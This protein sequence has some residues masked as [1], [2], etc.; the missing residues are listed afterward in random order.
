MH[1][2]V[3]DGINLI[4]NDFPEEMLSEIKGQLTFDNP[5]YKNAKKYSRYSY[6]KVPPYLMYYE[7]YKHSLKLPI[8]FNLKK[9]LDKYLSGMIRVI[10]ERNHVL[11][12]DIPEFVLELRKD[13]KQAADNYLLENLGRR[14]IVS[15]KSTIQLPTG[16]GKSILGLYLASQLKC[17][18]L[19]VV[20]KTDLVKGWKDDIALAFNNKVKVGLIKAQ[21][22]TVGDFI[23]IATIQTLNKLTPEEQSNLFNTFG[24]VIQDEMHHC[25]STTFS[26]VSKFNSRY[27]LGL[28]ATPERSDGLT[29]V[30]HLFFGDICYSVGE[31]SSNNIEDK[32]IVPV[33]VIIKPI[34]TLC[35]PLCSKTPNGYKLLTTVSPNGV[36]SLSSKEIDDSVRYSKI[37]YELKPRLSFLTLDNYVIKKSMEIIC[38]DIKREYDLGNSCIVF[39]TQ[40]EHIDLFY[41]ELTNNLNC[42]CVKY[43]GN[44]SERENQKSLD[45]ASSIKKLITLTTYAKTTEGTNNK[46]WEVAFLVSSLNNGKNVEQAIGRVRRSNDIKE[47]GKVYDY[48]YN[49]SVILKNHGRTRSERYRKLGFK[50]IDFTTN[51]PVQRGIF[52]RGY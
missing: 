13:Q 29:Q 15:M 33:N 43:Y 51:K 37:P 6:V 39:F 22:K 7:E 41:D 49:N 27:K 25:P 38:A 19:I 18:T 50:E 11:V 10:D 17:K 5:A 9:Y 32:D 23:T 42:E 35:D 16:K 28:T 8:G 48:R 2:V 26:L 12:D 3:N 34:Q 36:V 30:M 24:F 47:I 46:M 21:S 52:S 45:K 14:N 1:I 31:T 40:K 4:G 44:N 20:H